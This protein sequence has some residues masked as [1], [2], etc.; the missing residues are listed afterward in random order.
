MKERISAVLARPCMTCGRPTRDGAR[1][2]EHARGRGWGGTRTMPSGWDAVRARV[3]REEPR[4]RECGRTAV[5][6]DHIRA[7]AFGGSEDRLNL[8][9]LCAACHARKSS[10]EGHEGAKRRRASR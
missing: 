4:C 6:V 5:T 2:S 10:H 8:R 9:S 1:C 7:R 3:L